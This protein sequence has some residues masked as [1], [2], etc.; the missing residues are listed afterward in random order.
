MLGLDSRV[1]SV[2]WSQSAQDG[3][4]PTL[5]RR[6]HRS[7]ERR[8]GRFDLRLGLRAGDDLIPGSA[9]VPPPPG[10]LPP[11]IR[12]SVKWFRFSLVLELRAAPK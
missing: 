5:W 8:F 10:R 9:S 7:S 1:W 3:R 11:Q 6:I 2:V 12:K 4:L